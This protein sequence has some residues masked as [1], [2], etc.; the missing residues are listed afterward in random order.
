MLSLLLTCFEVKFLEIGDGLVHVL[1][2]AKIMEL[3]VRLQGADTIEVQINAISW[4][5]HWYHSMH[6]LLHD[7][8][9][10]CALDTA[11]ATPNMV[12]CSHAFE[13]G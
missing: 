11:A 2:S 9:V 4:N 1:K 3:Q 13:A 10:K 5:Q 8:F 12:L 7:A 6:E